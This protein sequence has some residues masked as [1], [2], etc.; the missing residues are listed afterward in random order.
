MRRN[1]RETVWALEW[2]GITNSETIDD[3]SIKYTDFWC[4]APKMRFQELIRKLLQ[5]KRSIVSVS[6]YVCVRVSNVLS[7]H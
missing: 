5:P 7:K 6:L 3:I 4:F 2:V 1:N